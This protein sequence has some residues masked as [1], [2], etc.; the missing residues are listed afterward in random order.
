MPPEAAEELAA[1]LPGTAR[2]IE[3]FVASAGWDQP[4]Q[5]FALVPT[6]ELL[7]AE[8]TLADQ[9]DADSLLTPIAQEALPAEDLGEALARISWPEQVVGCALVQEILVL[10]PEAEADLSDDA[11]QARQTAAEHPQRQEARL[12]ASVLR[13]GEQTCVMRLRVNGEDSDDVIQDSSLA[14]NLLT[15]LHGTFTD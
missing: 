12:V 8:P 3:E 2:E 11:E 1:A 14:P 5:L 13:A 6:R 15:A 7:T 10:P 4:V 9:L